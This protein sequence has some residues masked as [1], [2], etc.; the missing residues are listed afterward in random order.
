MDILPGDKVNQAIFNSYGLHVLSAQTV[1]DKDSIAKLLSHSIDYIDIDRSPTPDAHS[2][3]ATSGNH[4]EPA[5]TVKATYETGMAGV[6]LLF[7]QALAEGK[8]D[9]L[10]VD[11]SFEPLADS[12]KQ[13]NNLVSLMLSLE[14]GDDYT[15][16]HSV[17]VGMLSFYISQWMGKSSEFCLMAGKAGFLHDIGKS[18]IDSRLLT[19]PTKLTDE[20]YALVKRHSEFGKTILERSYPPDSPIV[21]GTLQHHERLDGSGYPMGLRGDQ[22]QPISR[23]LAVADIYS[24]MICSRAYQAERDMLF[25]LQELDRLSFGQIDPHVT[26]TFIRNMVPNFIGKT[27]VLDT[28]EQGTI[29]LTNSS[30]FFRPLIKLEERFIDLSKHPKLSI[31]KI[32]M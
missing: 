32:L 22:I 9:P 21:I 10:V 11:A 19:K 27:V 29:L 24:A 16:Q 12:F 20:E 3:P 30:D 4:L 2:G 26:Q 15:Y 1:L 17:Q 13:E 6:N 23:I 8:I 31:R 18:M 25:V 28:G 14:N 7:Q 5:L